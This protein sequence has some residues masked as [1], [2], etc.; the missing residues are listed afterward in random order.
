[1]RAKARLLLEILAVAELLVLGRLGDDLHVDQEGEQF[2]LGRRVHLRQ[3]RAE[4]FFGQRQVA[5]ADL[6]AVDLGEHLVGVLRAKRQAANRT[7]R[8]KC[9]AD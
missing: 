7:P 4:L 9:A 1:M 5:L 3:A 8:G 2:A 6:R